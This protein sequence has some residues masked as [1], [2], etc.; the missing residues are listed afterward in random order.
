MKGRK[1]GRNKIIYDAQRSNTCRKTRQDMTKEEMF[2]RMHVRQNHWLIVSSIRNVY[3]RLDRCRQHRL[4]ARGTQYTTS[5]IQMSLWFLPTD[6]RAQ[7]LLMKPRFGS[8]CSLYTALS[9]WEPTWIWA[10][11]WLS[12][13]LLDDN[14]IN[15]CFGLRPKRLN[16]D[17]DPIQCEDNCRILIITEKTDSMKHT[18][19]G[20]YGIKITKCRPRAFQEE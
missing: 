10:I 17:D 18:R 1:E 9:L 14:W 4:I 5:G 12:S 20:F 6:S 15:S 7:L 11:A 8:R 3:P 2:C 19:S 16:C 13:I